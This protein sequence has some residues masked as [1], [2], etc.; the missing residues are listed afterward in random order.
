MG[1][2]FIKDR[3]YSDAQ[4]SINFSYWKP[5]ESTFSS[6]SSNWV[7]G[8]ISSPLPE[9][10]KKSLGYRVIFEN[11]EDGC[12]AT[13]PSLKG[14][15]TEGDTIEEAYNYLHDAIEGWFQVAMEKNLELPEPDGPSL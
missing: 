12:V 15:V 7:Y 8:W 11:E 9:H 6:G 3:L 14:C 4:V 2:L 1:N 5:M 13:I 10:R